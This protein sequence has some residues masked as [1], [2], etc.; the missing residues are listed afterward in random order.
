MGK[1]SDVSGSLDGPEITRVR[2]DDGALSVSWSAESDP[3][4]TFRVYVFDGTRPVAEAETGSAAHAALPVDLAVAGGYEVAVCGFAAG[5]PRQWSAR[6]PVVTDSIAVER[7]ETDPVTG[8]LT[9]HWTAAEGDRFLVRLEANGLRAVPDSAAAGGSFTPDQ[10]PPPGVTVT[11]ALAHVRDHDGTVCVG[12]YGPRFAV[13]AQRP[14]LLAVDFADGVLSAKWTGVPGAD[15]YRVSVL[16]D[17]H[18][19]FQESTSASTTSLETTP[20]VTGRHAHAVVVQALSAA[21][22]GPPSAPLPVLLT[23]PEPTA[24]RSDR[25]TVSVDVAPPPGP[26]P[27]AYLVALLRDGV[28]VQRATLGVADTLMFAAPET[29]SPGAAYCVS[30][31]AQT[32]RSTGPAATAPAV[33]AAPALSSV[34]CRTDLT[35]TAEAGE[36]PVAPLAEARLQVDGVPGSPCRLDA[37]MTAVFPVPDGDVTVA[38]RGIDGIATGPWSDPVPAL[39]RR[40]DFT[41]ARVEADR[42]ALA[43]KGRPGAT[44]R[45]AVGPAAVVTAGRTADLP[46]SGD[47]AT[48]AEVAGVAT[49][50]VTT[51]ALPTNAVQIT[52]ASVDAGRRVTLTWTGGSL[53]LMTGLQP[54]VRWADNTLELDVARTAAPLVITLP[55]E[56]P[57]AATVAL[58]SV[59]L[60][61]SGPYGN[62]V[63][64]L[65]VAPT[66]LTVTYDGAVATAAWDPAQNASVDRYT[67][68]LSRPG[69]ADAVVI[70][71]DPRARFDLRLVAAS[72]TAPTVTVAAMAGGVARGLPS[73]PVPLF[74]QALFPG[75]SFLAPQ[76]GP[77]LAPTDITLGLPEL[78]TT[79]QTGALALP[80]G[81]TLAPGGSASYAYTLRIPAS[82]PVWAFSGRTDVPAQ[83]TALL[84][85]LELLGITSYGVA[86]LG[87][88]VSRSMPQTFT[89]TLFFAYGLRFDRGCFDLR[90]GLVLRVEY[91]NYQVTPGQQ[92]NLLSGY[93]TTA[94]ADY[95]VASCDRSGRRA[96]GLDAFLNALTQQGVV[97]P[98]PTPPPAGQSYGGGG[99][100]DLFAPTM[101]LPFTRVVYPPEALQT[102]S[103]GSSLPQQNVLFLAGT[104]LSALDTATDNVRRRSSPGPGVAAAYLRGRGTV[105]PM[106]RISVDGVP[107]LV[108]LGTTLGNVLASEG[109]R[110][111]DFALPLSGVTLRRARAAA[112]PA[113]G[114]VGDWPVTVGW[115]GLDPAVLDLPL[116]H[117]DRVGL[118]GGDRP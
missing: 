11:A 41:D 65:T 22:S 115:S 12:A 95:E 57:N 80:L 67:V 15:G 63:P 60:L 108:P 5:V 98:P 94:V 51:L 9:L 88:A 116:L 90:P 35:I 14:E 81:L 61:G 70:T 23:A 97:V 87:E 92:P 84:T 77:V 26:P 36:P 31:R 43:W 38:V 52:H 99:V 105:R 73:A 76:L 6:I 79:R 7:A 18:P 104:T 2:Y 54:V 1:K 55:D 13:P 75:R 3:G 86:A 28:T 21:G 30:V 39:T 106:V 83:W 56:V 17:G 33:L 32:G 59:S 19:C 49:G 64:L 50:P 29:V 46:L 58:R 96:D 16:S 82:S 48:V 10:P 34:V 27:T 20:G 24:V 74:T 53:P 100:I 118:P 68:V 4:T 42:V 109:R 103:P 117:G 44:F 102:T 69:A 45:A 8:A 47:T 78:F 112:V 91:E 85:Q 66:G 93:V 110:P 62:A 25:S 113:S 114:P 37:A 107:R 89:E 111:P 71:S 72:T 40:A 101:Q